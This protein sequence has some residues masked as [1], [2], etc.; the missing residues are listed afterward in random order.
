MRDVFQALLANLGILS[1]LLGAWS[2]TFQWSLR[3]TPLGRGAAM[4][5]AGGSCAVL[6]MAVPIEFR[7]G[8]ILDLR[9]VP[10]AFAGYFGGPIVGVLVG[11][12]AA[13]F[14]LH[15]GGVGAWPAVIGIAAV[16]VLG[17][18]MGRVCAR[19]RTS[20]RCTIT[21]SLLTAPTSIV[22]TF[23]VPA[24]IRD[25][26]VG[27]LAIPG[28]TAC[29]I[30]MLLVGA[31]VTNEL[32]RLK[33][34]AANQLYRSLMDAFP[35][36]LNAK[37]IE[38][39]FIAANPATAEMMRAGTAD[40]LLGKTDFDFYP[41]EVALKFRKD[42]EGA[43]ADGAPTIVEQHI[44]RRDGSSAWMAT[45][46]APLIDLSGKAIGLLTHNRDITELKDL[47][48]ERE[49]THARLNDALASMA[50]ALA[51]FDRDNKLVLCNEQYRQFFPKTASLRV[52]G[53]S[54]GDLLVAAFETGDI[55]RV[56]G[57][58]REA[59]I[60]NMLADRRS[61][62]QDLFWLGDG[63]VVSVR[64][65]PGSE[66]TSV[67][68][69]SD[70]SDEYRARQ[71]LADMN[72]RLADLARTDALTGVANRRVF[73]ETLATELGRSA[74]SGSSLSLLMIDI[75]RFKAFNDGHGHPA[76]DACLRQVAKL[77]GETLARPGDLVARYGGE[78]FAVILPDTNTSGAAAVA[79]R[80]RSAV[81][82]MAIT[83]AASRSPLSVTVSIGI[84][85]ATAVSEEAASA[86]V[87][88]A[89][90]ALYQAKSTGRNRVVA[91]PEV[92]SLASEM[93]R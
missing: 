29:V 72:R 14:R 25:E 83:T 40:A 9:A 21:L 13:L 93:P 49:R 80:L 43:L 75:D 37:D 76:G 66:D 10:I 47:R 12:I 44:T 84:A 45:L 54:L 63:R 8:I 52:P 77:L 56:D 4:V 26:V 91:A 71:Q 34:A 22:G 32:R 46:K 48:D 5:V 60:A 2:L 73:D 1:I 15:L 50:D 23:F 51:V 68:V 87:G 89:D 78:E 65:R 24:E 33:T 88:A 69:F 17:I 31:A 92:V 20:A 79:E 38:G 19:H 90:Q 82:V 36:P 42:E 55:A 57:A 11:A 70:I 18:V 3:L 30:G 74:R 59:W 27:A 67:V 85:T 7:P 39:R 53:A 16:T 86:L 64:I 35:E 62:R 28:M 61:S 58:E 81:E 41:Q 6:L